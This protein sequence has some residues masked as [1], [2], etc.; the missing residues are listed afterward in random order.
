MKKILLTVAV[1]S[2]L[3][4]TAAAVPAKRIYRTVTQPD[5]TTLTITKVGD[6]RI[7]FTL[8]DDNRLVVQDQNGQYNYAR[9][10]VATGTFVNTGIKALNAA[11]RPASQEYLTQDISTI[12]I[13]SFRQAR[14]KAN[15]EHVLEPTRTVTPQSLKAPTKAAALPQTGLGLFSGNF[16][17]T[18]KIKGLVILVEYQDV[19][20]NTGYSVDAKTYFNNL[21]HQKGFSEYGGTG[22]AVEYFEEQSGGLFQ[23]EFDLYG[24]VTLP[25]KQAYYGGNDSGGD[26]KNPHLMIAH[27]CEILDSSVDFS[28]YDND[29]DGYVDNVFVFYAGQGEASYGDDNT[30][31]PHS[32]NVSSGGYNCKLDGKIIDRYACT[33]E[34][35]YNTPDGVGTFIHEFSH[36][37]GLPDLYT[38]DYGSAS[39]LTPGAYS[40]LD[41]GPYNNNGRTPPAYSIYERNAMG[42]MVPRLLED[43]AETISLEHIATSND[44]CIIQT[45]NT[46]EFFLLENRQQSGWDKYIPGHGMLIWHID[47]NQSIWNRN[48]VNN[49]SSHQYV[50]IV[51]AGGTANNANTVTMRGYPWPGTSA[52]TSF[53]A[54]TSPAM[55][56]W[57]G[58]AID[59][60]LTDIAENNGII[61][62][63]VCADRALS[64]PTPQPPVVG[65]DNS[66][67]A[68]W[69]PVTGATD[70]LLTVEAVKDGGE[71]VVET[72]GMGSGSN[73]SL[74]TGWTSSTTE[75]Y[76][77]NGNYGKASPSLKFS[78]SNA[79]IQTRDMDSPIA[80]IEFWYKGMGTRNSGSVITVMGKLS[81]GAKAPQQNRAAAE[82]DQWVTLETITPQEMKATTATIVPEVNITAVKLVYTKDVGNVAID[83]L[84]LTTGGTSISAVEGYTDRS[85][86]G[87]TQH[88]VTNLPAGFNQFRYCVK[89]TDGKFISA[90]SQYQ[91]VNM[92]TGVEN[93]AND[94][95]DASSITI[96][97]RVV[98]VLTSAPRVNIYDASG[99]HIHSL[100]VS[101]GRLTVTLPQSGLFIVKAGNKTAKVLAH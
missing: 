24:P 48:I 92:T 50:D 77:T 72:A 57:A 32:W 37:M 65:N 46:N 52:K 73:V 5:G 11:M 6:E 36:V 81:A 56:S 10:D 38:T 75:N 95:A 2:G 76:T 55:K 61:T 31:W 42:W 71:P 43:Q 58:T 22:C 9:A 17:S 100:P 97:D 86:G 98:T 59:V 28:Q 83:D 44:G 74:P 66:F 13:E 69:S 93:I 47:F 7:H 33:N 21:L 80:K 35:E 3:A 79:Y 90:P 85:T 51:E 39:A 1:A 12:D 96:V 27:A 18:G 70:Y 53:T 34:W 45:E 29:G 4:L 40:V 64:T 91:T 62:F 60:P 8:T 49:S 25:Y 67:T 84:T 88:T 15:P 23:P 94:S 19:K 30:V 14:M 99:R 63:N 54:T 89:A 20:F 16:P 78:S 68:T 26:D 101:D 41:Y 87:A 82:A